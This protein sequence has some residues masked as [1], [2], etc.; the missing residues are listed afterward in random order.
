MIP[1]F[2]QT[3]PHCRSAFTL[4]EL[5]TVIAIIGILAAIIIP[6]VGKVREAA[7]T[8]ACQSNLRQFGVASLL[9]AQDH[10]GC[11]NYQTGYGKAGATFWYDRFAPYIAGSDKAD[12]RNAQ[13]IWLC[14]AVVGRDPNVADTT[15]KDYAM[16]RGTCIDRAE[17]TTSFTA[18]RPITDFE[19]P[20][21]KIYILDVNSSTTIVASELFTKGG[22]KIA[23]RHNNKANI[24]FLDGHVRTLGTPPLP[25]VQSTS[26]GEK[27]LY[28]DAPAP[29]F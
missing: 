5:L 6:T 26:E 3:L 27:W 28:H 14:P 16:S 23:L 18:S 8:A 22:T 15:K 2:P 20:S 21:R 9:Y 19:T 1:R 13:T 4:I 10:K 7:R 29:D 25:R 11:L 24:L 17:N 12:V